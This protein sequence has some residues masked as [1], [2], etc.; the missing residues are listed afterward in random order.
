VKKIFV[1]GPEVF[2]QVPVEEGVDAGVGGAHEVEDA[3][4][5][6]LPLL[7]GVHGGAVRLGE[8][9]D[10]SEQVEGEPAEGEDGGDGDDDAVGPPPPVVLLIVERA[11]PEP[12]AEYGR[13]VEV[14]LEEEET[15]SDDQKMY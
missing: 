12:E 6:L 8:D 9:G 11:R 7:D 10:Y 3:V 2:V 4:K 14:S 13:D 1:D 5:Q 15:E